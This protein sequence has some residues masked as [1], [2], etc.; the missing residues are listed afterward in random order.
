MFTLVLNLSLLLPLANNPKVDQYT[1][2]LTNAY[3]VILG[4]PWFILQKS[5]RG[6]SLPKGAHWWS[7]S[8]L[9]L[10][11]VELTLSGW[12]DSNLH[13]GQGDKTTAVSGRRLAGLMTSYTFIY[14]G[15]FF[16]LADG[17]NT[18]GTLVGIVQNQKIQFSFLQSTYL[19]LVSGACSVFSCY[20]FWY[21]QKYKKISTKKMFVATNIVTVS[22]SSWCL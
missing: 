13:R 10:A 4:V 12:L 7:V 9:C 22:R 14:L 17:L 6:P 20:A 21:L 1:I 16:L 19:T 11:I 8:G 2:G 5:R 3:W 15:A 18:N